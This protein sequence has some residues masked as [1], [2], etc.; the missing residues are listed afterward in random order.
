MILYDLYWWKYELNG[1]WTVT[2]CVFFQFLTMFTTIVGAGAVGTGAASR[3]GSGS[4]SG[5]DQKMWLLA[6]P[7]PHPAPQH[8]LNRLKKCQQ[9]FFL[10]FLYTSMNLTNCAAAPESLDPLKRDFHL[11][12]WFNWRLDDIVRSLVRRQFVQKSSLLNHKTSFLLTQVIICFC[13][14]AHLL[15]TVYEVKQAFSN[16]VIRR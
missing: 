8:C 9:P 13:I 7:A 2:V 11:K 6:V 15:Y 4:G 3:Y 10:D 12:E 1:L 5:S 14:S 16:N